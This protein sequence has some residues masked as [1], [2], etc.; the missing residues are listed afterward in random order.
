MVSRIEKC[1]LSCSSDFFPSRGLRGDA[2]TGLQSSLLALAA[3]SPLTAALRV[4]LGGRT[5]PRFSN[6]VNKAKGRQVA[7]QRE[8]NGLLDRPQLPIRPCQLSDKNNQPF[9]FLTP[10][11]QPPAPQPA[12]PY[13]APFTAPATEVASRSRLAISA[14]ESIPDRTRHSKPR[15]P[16]NSSHILIK[17]PGGKGK[18]SGGKSSGGK[19]SADAAKKQ[20]SHSTRAGLQV[21]WFVL[22]MRHR[23]GAFWTREPA[24]T[25]VSAM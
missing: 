18:S 21:S 8:N 25:A 19:T 23:A 2:P 14:A 13:I 7:G 5:P 10:P 6:F 3:G 4:Y 9:H 12:A 16:P 17:M 20:Q 15:T 24:P 1:T 11:P 22:V